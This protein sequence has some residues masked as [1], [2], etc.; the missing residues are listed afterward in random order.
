MKRPAFLGVGKD[1]LGKALAGANR[2]GVVEVAAA[3]ALRLRDSR[4]LV[5]EGSLV[6][7]PLQI[8]GV[9]DAS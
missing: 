1:C 5:G 6:L 9:K 7:V 2:L 4:E 8:V 3:G